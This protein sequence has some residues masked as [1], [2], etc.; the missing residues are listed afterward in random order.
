MILTKCS[1]LWVAASVLF[2]FSSGCG[3]G[4]AVDTVP[5]S[6]IVTLDGEPIEG[7]T[8]T[9]MP[10]TGGADKIGYAVTDSQGHFDVATRGG[11]PGLAVGSYRVLFQKL[12]MPDG[13]PIPADVMAADVDARNALPAIYSDSDQAAMTAEIPEGGTSELKFELVSRPRR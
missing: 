8:V 10:Q 3:G 5:A 12:T 7:V 6:G 11:M 2:V 1:V 13:S 4:S 9:F